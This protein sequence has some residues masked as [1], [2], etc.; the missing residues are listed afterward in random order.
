MRMS[1]GKVGLHIAAA[2]KMIIFKGR[3]NGVALTC[4]GSALCA[5][6]VVVLSFL[7]LSTQA[8]LSAIVPLLQFSN[9]HHFLLCQCCVLLLQITSNCKLIIDLHPSFLT[10]IY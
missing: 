5:Q 8:T 7:F 1:L 4:F 10:S 9:S 2:E 6:L 3:G